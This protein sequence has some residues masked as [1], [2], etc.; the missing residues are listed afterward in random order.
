MGS[1]QMSDNL[2]LIREA[3]W[4]CAE[5]QVRLAK[6]ALAGETLGHADRVVATVESLT[7]ARLAAARGD[8][9]G[10]GLFIALQSQLAELLDDAGL[11]DSGDSH[12]GE[13]LAAADATVD[14]VPDGSMGEI[15]GAYLAAADNATPDAMESAQHH[16]RKWGGDYIG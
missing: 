6:L 2:E 10:L 12:R 1:G 16:R 3:A 13:S 9:I 4:G 11:F 14:R 8:M 7:F 5:S 15:L